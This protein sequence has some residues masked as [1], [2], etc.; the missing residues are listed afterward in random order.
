MIARPRGDS[1]R[2]TV[3][4]AVALLLAA[5]GCLTPETVRGASARGDEGTR[6]VEYVSWG[7]IKWLYMPAFLAPPAAA[8]SLTSRLGGTDWRYPPRTSP[9]NVL[10]KLE[11]AYVNR[12]AEAYLDCLGYGMTFYI[13]G[14][15]GGLPHYWG[16]DTEQAI[17]L[18]MF[19]A[20]SDVE[21]VALDLEAIS[22]QFDMGADP[23]DP[24]DDR[25]IYRE[26]C[27]LEV[28]TSSRT[29]V[30]RYSHQF[31]IQL[32]P[33]E[34]GPSGEDLWEI[35]DWLDSGDLSAVEASSWTRLKAM[36]R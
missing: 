2:C 11:A 25:W 4:V 31:E 21:S 13:T 33:D 8:G 1:A 30:S 14:S 6:S 10:A 34:V 12:D 19:G 35:V 5:A 20:G 7:S 29:L 32:D 26:D 28:V 27:D 17:H 16:Y 23:F 18:L 9:G 22:I 3:V 36:F 24:S 15:G